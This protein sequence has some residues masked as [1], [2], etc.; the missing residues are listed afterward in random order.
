M[1]VINDRASAQVLHVVQGA[2]ATSNAANV[3]YT[4]L[5]G[6]CVLVCLWDSVAKLGGMAHFVFPEEGGDARFG[7]VAIAAVLDQLHAKGGQAARFQASLFGG[8]KVQ[9]GGQDIGQRNAGFAETTLTGLGISVTARDLG[10]IA[11]RRVRFSPATGQAHV[12]DHNEGMPHDTW[13]GFAP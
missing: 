4:A 6:A 9:D 11:V 7:A 2:V 1:E 10:G 13:A 8:A 12:T 3:T 5:I